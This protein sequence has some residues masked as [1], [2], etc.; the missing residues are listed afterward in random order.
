M[1]LFAIKKHGNIV[2]INKQIY[3]FGQRNIF[4]ISSKRYI[5][6]YNISL[7]LLYHFKLFINLVAINYQLIIKIVILIFKKKMFV[8]VNV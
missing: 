6:L 8:I 7:I 5:S 4:I 1:L 3:P 2:I